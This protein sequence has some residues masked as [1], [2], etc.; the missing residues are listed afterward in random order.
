[1]LFKIVHKLY[2]YHLIVML[3]F[4]TI[5]IYSNFWEKI[6]KLRTFTGPENLIQEENQNEKN[7]SST[8]FHI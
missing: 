4:Y 8:Q 7:T 2:V 3:I 6:H 5:K 1:M